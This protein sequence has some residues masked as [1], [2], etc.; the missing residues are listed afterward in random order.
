MLVDASEQL[1]ALAISFVVVRARPMDSIKSRAA[2]MMRT[3][4]GEARDGLRGMERYLAYGPAGWTAVRPPKLLDK[5][6]TGRYRVAVGGKPRRAR[7]IGR[8]DVAHAMLA[9]ADDPVTLRQGVGV[10]YWVLSGRVLSGRIPD[11]RG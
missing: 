5:P 8:A 3:P 10:A 4:V 2:S 9:M 7:V 6:L 1:A 11:S